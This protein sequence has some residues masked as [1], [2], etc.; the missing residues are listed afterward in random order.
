MTLVFII[1]F[2]KLPFF[3]KKKKVLTNE[4]YIQLFFFPRVLLG[5]PLRNLE[6]KYF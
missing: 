4:S 5:S 1:L 2:P 6:T 3:L